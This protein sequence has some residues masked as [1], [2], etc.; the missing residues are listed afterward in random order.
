MG[1]SERSALV[2]IH[3]PTR[4]FQRLKP[5]LQYSSSSS[6]SDDILLARIPQ[7]IPKLAHLLKS[8]KSVATVEP[9]T[10]SNIT[11]GVSLSSIAIGSLR[12]SSGRPRS[13]TVGTSRFRRLGGLLLLPPASPSPRRGLAVAAMVSAPAAFCSA[14]TPWLDFFWGE[15]P[16]LTVAAPAD[17][18]L[19]CASTWVLFPS[20]EDLPPVDGVSRLCGVTS[21]PLRKT[22]GPP[23]PAPARPLARADTPARLLEPHARDIPILDLGRSVVDTSTVVGKYLSILFGLNLL[24]FTLN[25]I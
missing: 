19:T 6:S 20:F 11:V 16:P 22:R 14:S 12:P 4:S 3:R 23:D 15:T 25:P 9:R 1:A 17:G 7:P 5:L 2:H 8:S 13:S 18:R 21:N 24:F 10:S